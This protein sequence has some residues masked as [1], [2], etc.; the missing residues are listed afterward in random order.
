MFQNEC[1]QTSGPRDWTFVYLNRLPE[2][3]EDY[4]WPASSTAWWPENIWNSDKI[5]EQE[6]KIDDLE[7]K[8]NTIEAE[9]SKLME[10]NIDKERP[11]RSSK[12]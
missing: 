1:R 7:K 3:T 11:Q 12:K 6:R 8:I 10:K 9:K 2:A 5:N 4:P